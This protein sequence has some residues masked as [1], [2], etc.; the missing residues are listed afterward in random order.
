M[1]VRPIRPTGNEDEKN[2]LETYAY[3]YYDVCLASRRLE[4]Q[5]EQS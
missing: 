3:S 2:R 5:N 4:W 1:G